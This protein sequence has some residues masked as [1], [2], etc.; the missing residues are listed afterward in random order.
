MSELTKQYFDKQINSQTKEI[1][2][3]V[4]GRISSVEEKLDTKI[5]TEVAELAGMVERRFD[6]LEQKLDVR[7]EVDQLKVK[8]NKVWQALN[9]K[10]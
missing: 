10:N 4:D 5:E 7:A 8:M 9:I 1:K 2:S 6:K 3:Y